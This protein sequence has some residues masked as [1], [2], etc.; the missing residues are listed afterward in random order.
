[1]DT[2]R[3]YFLN[4]IAAAVLSSLV[5][6]L[7][8]RNT[9]TSGAIKLLTGLVMILCTIAPTASL[10]FDGIFNMMDAYSFAAEQA[11]DSGTDFAENEMKSIIIRNTEAYILEK[12]S[13][14]G[15]K[16][17]VCVVLARE[18]PFAPASI[19]LHGKT[20][21]YTKAVISRWITDNLGIP[22]ELIHWK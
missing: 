5:I 21:P 4:V 6:G 20:A 18:A 11:V 22:E 13:S 17:Q 8:E 2:I 19:T 9:V 15:A 7:T 14:L 12:A 3:Q 10:E 16:V 1:M